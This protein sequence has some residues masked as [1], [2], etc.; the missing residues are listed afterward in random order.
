[1][2]ELFKKYEYELSEKKKLLFDNYYIDLI[3]KNKV[4]NLTAITEKEQV[5]LKH[6]LDS[7]LPLYDIKDNAKVL[8]IGTGAGF[9]GIPLKI[10]NDTLNVVLL[11]SLNKRINFLN[12][13][14]EKLNLKNIKA[15]HSRAEDYANVSRETFDYVVS[16]AVARLNTLLEYCLPFV[17]V[18]GMF[19]AYKSINSNEELDECANALKI[20]G[21]KI[22]KI[23]EI[24]LEG[25]L[26]TLI[27][28][29]KVKETPKKYPRGQNK[30][31]NQP[32]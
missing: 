26:R 3:E 23:K 8:D 27:Y 14:I 25:N 20:L 32:L 10:M 31:K 22:E 4:M 17:K 16:R 12:E 21:G 1:M 9:P 2:N 11:D 5:Y 29:K 15:I 19:I 28:I 13:E 30:P 24:D 7:V 6:F 18:G